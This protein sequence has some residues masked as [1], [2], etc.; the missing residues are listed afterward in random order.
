[1][2]PVLA[3]L[4]PR[5]RMWLYRKFCV[6]FHGKYKQMSNH[7]TKHIAFTGPSLVNQWNYLSYRNTGKGYLQ[8][9]EWGYLQKH[10]WGLLTRAWV[11]YLQGMGDS[12]ATTSLRSPLRHGYCVPR[13]SWETSGQLHSKSTTPTDMDVTVRNRTHR[14][15]KY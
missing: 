3:S 14:V 8:E 4:A 9:H 6:A 1:M 7:P 15:S 13:D 5:I 10:G 11:K 12:W 2:Q